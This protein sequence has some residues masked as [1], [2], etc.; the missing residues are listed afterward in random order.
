M[1]DISGT[2]LIGKT[3]LLHQPACEY[4]SCHHCSNGSSE[5]THSKQFP[6]ST[7]ERGELGFYRVL[8]TL[9]FFP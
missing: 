3:L 7:E 4:S 9:K 5:C 2:N 1:E 8:A 6:R